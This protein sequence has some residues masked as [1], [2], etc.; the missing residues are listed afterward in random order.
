MIVFMGFILTLVMVMMNQKIDLVTDNY[1]Q[2]ELEYDKTYTA[3]RNYE[4]AETP[5]LT[6]IENNFLVIN[7]P[8]AFQEDSIHG[9]LFCPNNALNDLNFSFVATD[10]IQVPLKKLPKGL[11]EL[12]LSGTYKGQTFE[13]KHQL[14]W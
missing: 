9:Y 6:H 4:N 10:K 8:K 12:T 5:I 7:I 13:S 2:K 11:Y 14:Q 3:E 1:Y